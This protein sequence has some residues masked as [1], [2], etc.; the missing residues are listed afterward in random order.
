MIRRAT[1]LRDALAMRKVRNTC[2]GFMTRD[3]SKISRLRQ[4]WWWLNRP[5]TTRPYVLEIDWKIVG[6]G[7]L[8]VD[9]PRGLLSA[10]LLPETRGQGLGTVIFRFLSEEAEDSGLVPWLEVLES[11]EAGRRVYEKLGFVEV[12]RDDNTIQMKRPRP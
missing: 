9:P 2:R 1:G 7:L 12:S 5:S 4:L 6:Y 3:Q 11:N 10:G 8:V